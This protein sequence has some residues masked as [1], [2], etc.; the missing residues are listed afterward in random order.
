MTP[1]PKPTVPTNVYFAV[2]RT[3]IN[4]VQKAKS[5]GNRP[6]ENFSW[7]ATK[8]DAAVRSGASYV[9]KF[10]VPAAGFVEM[11]N[12]NACKVNLTP[13]IPIANITYTSYPLTNPATFKQLLAT[14]LL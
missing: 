4:S 10:T 5:L 2:D 14:P 3:L 12:N 7:G 8:L 13:A 9:L 1:P 11:C 6:G